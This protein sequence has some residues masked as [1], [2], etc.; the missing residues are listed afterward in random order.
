MREFLSGVSAVY[1]FFAFATAVLRSF[2]WKPVGCSWWLFTAECVGCGLLWPY[3]A[4]RLMA[5]DFLP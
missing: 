5:K 2:G 1:W 3:V 4:C